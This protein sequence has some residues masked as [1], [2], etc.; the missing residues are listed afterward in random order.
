MAEYDIAVVAR[1][2]Q[3]EHR[4]MRRRCVALLALFVML[5]A[6]FSVRGIG[7]FAASQADAAPQH[8]D[9]V[10]Y[11]VRPGDTLWSY[12]EQ[13]T[14]EGENV[15]DTVDELMQLNDL[16]SGA[17]NPGQRLVVPAQ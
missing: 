15:S 7:G 12:A 17:L 8:Q 3:D 13:I 1:D 5:I 9:V 4:F 6:V 11:T 16:D 14:P 2:G 10:S